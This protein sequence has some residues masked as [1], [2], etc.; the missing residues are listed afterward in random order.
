MPHIELLQ[1]V[2]SMRPWCERQQHSTSLRLEA[3]LTTEGSTS[4]CNSCSH[5][6]PAY[7]PHDT[8]NPGPQQAQTMYL[9][10][11][12]T[13]RTTDLISCYVF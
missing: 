4:R 10:K 9:K 7:T 8:G 2:L 3:A 5:C 11:K 6:S 1:Y 12:D 13:E